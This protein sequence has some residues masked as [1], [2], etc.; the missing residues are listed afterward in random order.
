[1]FEEIPSL[2]LLLTT[3]NFPKGG[4]FM[5]IE[6]DDPAR[7]TAIEVAVRRMEWEGA[8]ISEESFT[9]TINPNQEPVLDDR[10]DPRAPRVVGKTKG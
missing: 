5:G 7:Q 9:S 8:P 3:C 6:Q 1:M 10:S 2:S 4:D